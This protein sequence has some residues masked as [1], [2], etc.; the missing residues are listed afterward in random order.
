MQ[1][2]ILLQNDNPCLYTHFEAYLYINT[3]I[4]QKY[5]YSEHVRDLR[6]FI[7]PLCNGYVKFLIHAVG[8]I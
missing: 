1:K 5:I 7:R 2:R 6:Y 8:R 3:E 4:N